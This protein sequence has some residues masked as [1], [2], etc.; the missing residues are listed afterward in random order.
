MARLLQTAIAASGHQ[1]ELVSNFRS[2]DGSGD[3]A[4]QRRLRDIG[5]RIAH[6]LVS[7]YSSAGRQPELWFTYHVY[8]KAPDWIGPHVSAA[9]QIPYVVA[10][11]SFASKQN[12]GPW[13]I[14][15]EQ[16]RMGI[17]TAQAI[18]S[19]NRQDDP[20]L[21][22]LMHPAC[23]LIEI[24]PFMSL[25][26]VNAAIADRSMVARKWGA[27]LS[28]P[29]LVCVAMMREGDKLNSFMQL[30]R[31]L[32][33]LTDERWHLIIV[34]DGSARSRVAQLF[35]PVATRVTMTGLLDRDEIFSILKASDVYV[36]PAV[37]EAYGMALLEAQA[38]GLPVIASASG[39][40]PQIVEHRL[41]GL[42]SRASHSEMMG[43]HIRELLHDP[44]RGRKMGALAENKCRSQHNL[45]E[46]SV[47]LDGLF[48]R[49][50]RSA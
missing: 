7:A 29:W 31:T 28:E 32:C 33:S 3:A 36:W 30:A 39:G 23:E 50:R 38:C 11:A 19:L 48:V 24:R 47:A 21:Q 6:R 34:G 27:P 14:G 16:C 5:T 46:A 26:E 44:V 10:E 25:K 45:I 15:H 12:D 8:H 37:N 22:G 40:I 9:L 1:V 18:V 17:C 42:L 4:R 49:L 41:T 2:W 35:E 43:R 13:R 20:C